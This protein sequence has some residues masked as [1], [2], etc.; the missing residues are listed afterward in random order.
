MKKITILLIS[1]LL[2]ACSTNNTQMANPWTSYETLN[3]AKSNVSFDVSCPTEEGAT[4]QVMNK[5][6]FEMDYGDVSL[7]KSK[8]NQDIS[9]DYNEYDHTWNMNYD[10]MSVFCKGKGDKIHCAIWYRGEFAYS[11]TS[12]NGITE[13]M[14]HDI[15]NKFN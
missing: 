6:L 4:Y 15:V 8:S 7:R 9:G 10:G 1:V 5:E 14:F 13:E 11:M 3:E 2:C 12:Q